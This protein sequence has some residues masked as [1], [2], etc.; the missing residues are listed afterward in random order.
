[1]ARNLENQMQ[2]G[3]MLTMVTEATHS[4]IKTPR[5]RRMLRCTIRTLTP[6]AV[7][8]ARFYMRSLPALQMLYPADGRF[9]AA[10]AMSLIMESHV[11]MQ[12]CSMR[13]CRYALEV[14]T[15]FISPPT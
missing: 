12:S 14:R 3:H 11:R 7:Q 2:A 15:Q 5:I 8:T 6:T 13:L 1:M 10:L 9:L 4:L